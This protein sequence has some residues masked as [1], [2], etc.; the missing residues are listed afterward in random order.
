MTNNDASSDC[1]FGIFWVIQRFELL[2][3]KILHFLGPVGK[4]VPSCGEYEGDLRSC[5]YAGI[6]RGSGNQRPA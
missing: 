1:G 5:C 4:S 3:A 2:V 6:L